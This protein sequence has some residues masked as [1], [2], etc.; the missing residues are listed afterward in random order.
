MD[1]S[2]LKCG[3]FRAL[4]FDIFWQ[5]KCRSLTGDILTE[6]FQSID[7][8][9]LISQC[10]GHAETGFLFRYSAATACFSWKPTDCLKGFRTRWPEPN[11]IMT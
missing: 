1:N 4:E 3:Y 8:Q 6:N 7:Q 10:Y 11:E 2:S 5:K 9:I